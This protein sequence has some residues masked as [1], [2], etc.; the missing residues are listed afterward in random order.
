MRTPSKL[1]LWAWREDAPEKSRRTPAP[2]AP[3]GSR[4]T[5]PELLCRT[6]RLLESPR[7]TW[8]TK[9]PEQTG[10]RSRAVPFQ[11][12]VLKGKNLR[13]FY[14]L[15][16]FSLFYLEKETPVGLHWGVSNFKILETQGAGGGAGEVQQVLLAETLGKLVS[17]PLCHRE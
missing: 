6:G 1:P 8:S 12:G 7:G 17:Q 14:L 16:Y 9:S 5:Q 11:P 15:K 13:C 4:E 10:L 2:L 3:R